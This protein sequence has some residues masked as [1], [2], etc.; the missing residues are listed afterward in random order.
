MLVVSKVPVTLLCVE[1]AADGQAAVIVL[2]PSSLSVYTRLAL[3]ADGDVQLATR[4]RPS[5]WRLIRRPASR[6]L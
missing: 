1:V 4:Q 3:E 6:L 2:V 5:G